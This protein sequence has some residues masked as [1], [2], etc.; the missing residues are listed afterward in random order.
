[1]VEATDRSLDK[2]MRIVTILTE[3]SHNGQCLGWTPEIAVVHVVMEKTGIFISEGFTYWILF[4]FVPDDFKIFAPSD[5]KIFV[6]GDFKIFVSDNFNIFAP[7]DLKF[8]VPDYFKIFVPDDF[9]F[10]DSRH[11]V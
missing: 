5:F 7:A 9:K 6:P 4:I 11:R 8:V 3:L 1:M 2:R 10:I